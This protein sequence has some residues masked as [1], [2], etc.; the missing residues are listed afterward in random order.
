[1][2]IA[3]YDAV[4]SLCENIVYNYAW[5]ERTLEPKGSGHPALCPFS[6]PGRPGAGGHRHAQDLGSR[7]GSLRQV[8]PQESYGLTIKA[9]VV[10]K[11]K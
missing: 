1:M 5:D 7:A 9:G 3:M 6:Y 2:Y 8:K 4:I 10:P 11:T